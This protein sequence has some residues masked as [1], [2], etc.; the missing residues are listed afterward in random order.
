MV[1]MDESH[2]GEC[3][4]VYTWSLFTR[5]C[6]WF[7]QAV[8]PLLECTVV[9]TPC[10]SWRWEG[11]KMDEVGFSRTTY[12]F[13]SVRH[14][15]RCWGRIQWAATYHQEVCLRMELGNLIDFEFSVRPGERPELPTQESGCSKCLGI[16]L[17]VESRGP[18]CTSICTGMC[19]CSGL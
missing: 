7:H 4:W 16:C 3:G 11:S 1:L 8:V 12:G 19:G 6:S 14:K 10:S 5:G 17:S 18:H 15:P 9:W 2:W 13:P